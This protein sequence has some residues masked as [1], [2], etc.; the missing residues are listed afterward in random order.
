MSQGDDICFSRIDLSE[1]AGLT[2]QDVQ[3]VISG[4]SAEQIGR[5]SRCLDELNVLC[6]RDGGATFVAMYLL[7][8]DAVIRMEKAK[9]KA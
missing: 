1:G 6:Q 9:D 5:V 8:Q 4:L 2:E 7:V 3:K